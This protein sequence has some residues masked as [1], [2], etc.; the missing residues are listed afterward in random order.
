MNPAQITEFRVICRLKPHADTVDSGFPVGSQAFHLHRT[1][2]DLDRDLCIGCN[3]IVLLQSPHDGRNISGI[4]DG[5][6]SP[7]QENGIDLILPDKT[8]LNSY[9]FQQLVRILPAH[10]HVTR[11]RQKIAIGAFL[12]TE[13]NVHIDFQFLFIHHLTSVRS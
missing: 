8:A 2:I 4:Q 9:L 11:K 3:V 13:R 5:R 6:R 1:R 12:C 7:S 10:P